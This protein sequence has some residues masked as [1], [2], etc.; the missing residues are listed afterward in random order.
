MASSISVRDQEHHWNF[1]YYNNS[2]FSWN[3]LAV[4]PS[5]SAKSQLFSP[6][7]TEIIAGGASF[8]L[9]YDRLVAMAPLNKDSWSCTALIVLIKKVKNCKLLIGVYLDSSFT[10]IC[11]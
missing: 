9:I 5:N 4:T 11:C 1:T 2:V 3:N 6:I 8:T 10:R 7:N